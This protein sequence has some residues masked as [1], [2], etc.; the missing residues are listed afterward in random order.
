MG[1]VDLRDEVVEALVRRT[2]HGKSLI[3]QLAAEDLEVR[4][5]AVVAWTDCDSSI[6]ALV[7]TLSEESLAVEAACALG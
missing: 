5:S 7:N 6:T 2:G 4:R 3:A 1:R